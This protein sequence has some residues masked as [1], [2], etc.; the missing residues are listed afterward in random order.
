MEFQDRAVLVTGATGGI[1]QALAHRFAEAG[2]KVGVHTGSRPPKAREL[3]KTLPGQGHAVLQ[4]DLREASACKALIRACQEAL[5]SLDVL[6]NNAGVYQE[7]PPGEVSFEGWRQAWER[8]LAVNLLGPAHLSFFAG[9]EMQQ[10]GQGAIVNVTSRGAFRGEPTAPAYGAA[11]AGLNALTGSLAKAFAPEVRVAGVAPGFVATPMVQGLLESPEG[12]AIKAQSPHNRVA[13]PEEVA[14]A[15]AFL[16]S[17][18]CPWAT[19]AI[20]DVNGASYLRI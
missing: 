18:K 1:G 12:E 2:A 9:R 16:A 8:T 14:E 19:G 7:H 5:G 13:R 3:V 11:K 10:Q 6:V 20:L 17:E 15:V 4:A